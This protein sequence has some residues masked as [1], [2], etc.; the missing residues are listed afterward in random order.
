MDYIERFKSIPLE[1]KRR[2]LSAQSMIDHEKI[3]HATDEEVEEIYYQLFSSFD[4]AMREVL[5]ESMF[6][7]DW[8][9]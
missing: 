3:K 1:T 2:D 8:E 4:M 9:D 6:D 5:G 7:D